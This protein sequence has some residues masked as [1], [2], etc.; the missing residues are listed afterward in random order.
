MTVSTYLADAVKF[1]IYSF[2]LSVYIFFHVFLSAAKFLFTL[3]LEPGDVGVFT[4]AGQVSVGPL[5]VHQ[6]SGNSLD[7]NHQPSSACF[8][9]SVFS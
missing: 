3:T 1:M 5:T 4:A 7:F 6:R 2:I 8:S 9:T